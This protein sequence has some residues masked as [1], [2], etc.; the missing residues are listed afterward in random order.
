MREI[1]FRGK[2]ID[3]GEW[4]YGDFINAGFSH[5]DGS[6]VVFIQ[7]DVGEYEV[8]TETVGQFTGLTDKNGKK[9]FEDD[10]LEFTRKVRTGTQRCRSSRRGQ[11]DSFA[12]YESKK[13]HGIV[14]LG[15]FKKY[16]GPFGLT[17][18]AEVKETTSYDSYFFGS[19]KAGDIPNKVTDNLSE[20]L[21]N[22]SD[23]EVI[24]TVYDSPELLGESHE[25]N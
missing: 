1:L 8:I 24:G 4:I 18:Y 2:R 13:L 11:Y 3:S 16:P 9:I 23:Y 12:I 25:H 15:E 10:I 17:A 20:M 7:N 14:R 19:G 22:P 5:V 6:P 21:K